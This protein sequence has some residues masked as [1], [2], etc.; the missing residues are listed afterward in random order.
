MYQV[1]KIAWRLQLGSAFIPAV[2]LLI[3][4][5]LCP[6]NMPVNGSESTAYVIKNRPAGTLR[7]IATTM[8]FNLSDAFGILPFKPLAI[9][10]TYTLK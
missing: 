6:G 2:P 5:Y 4:I 8:L 10:T 9:Y 1:G 3:G 7:N